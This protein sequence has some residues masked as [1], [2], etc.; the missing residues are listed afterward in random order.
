MNA[1]PNA[2][3][4]TKPR[5]GRGLDAL[6]GGS[7]TS[8]KPAAASDADQ[9]KELPVDLIQRGKYQP[10][11]HMDE[12]A[13]QDLAD[14][15]KTQG[16]I[17]PVVVRKIETGNYEIIAGERRW[18]AAQMAGLH[19]VPVIVRDIPDEAAVVVA[20]IEN[21][22]RENLN[23]VEEAAG[24]QRLIDEFGLTHEQAA[25][26][27]GRSR[28]AVS[29]LLRL[30]NLSDAP[31]KLLESGKIDMGH[32]RAMLP[33]ESSKQTELATAVVNKGLSVRQAEAMAKKL[34]SGDNGKNKGGKPEKSADIKNLE[35]NISERLGANVNIDHKPN[36]KGRLVIEYHSSDEL[37]GII[38]KIG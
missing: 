38:E 17:Q 22:Q 21:I 33:L 7:K 24:L 35:E 15:I 14:S 13:L 20:L 4:H 37:E 29:N 8:N 2:K 25:D 11:T 34:L 9:L 19:K 31:R 1:K 12:S 36:G 16:V 10:R 28:S 30:L 3:P 6:L 32:A 18:R 27:I 26:S 23:P 5:L